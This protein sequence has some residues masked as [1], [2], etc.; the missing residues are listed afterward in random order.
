MDNILIKCSK[1]S[2]SNY[3]SND[4]ESDLCLV[5]EERRLVSLEKKLSKTP[6]RNA[7]VKKVKVAMFKSKEDLTKYDYNVCILKS[8]RKKVFMRDR[9]KKHYIEFIK[10]Q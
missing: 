5:C 9:C 2:C 1:S 6:K 3:R 8:C 10:T 4:T 7:P